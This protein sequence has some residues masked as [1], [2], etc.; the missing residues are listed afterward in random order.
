MPITGAVAHHITRPRRASSGKVEG[1]RARLLDKSQP[2]VLFNSPITLGG[3]LNASGTSVSNLTFASCTDGN[4]MTSGNRF[5][6]KSSPDTDLSSNAE[7]PNDRKRYTNRGTR[8]LNCELKETTSR[9]L[10]R[11]DPYRTCRAPLL[12]Y[13]QFLWPSRLR[14]KIP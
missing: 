1:E 13:L 12:L 8:S 7:P 3:P 10:I 11:R 6:T 9:S 5:D 4:C 14:P 2:K